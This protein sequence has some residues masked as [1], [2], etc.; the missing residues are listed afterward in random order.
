MADSQKLVVDAVAESVAAMD[1]DTST[2]TIA[3]SADTLNSAQLPDNK[4]TKD[5]EKRKQKKKEKKRAKKLGAAVAS[6]QVGSKKLLDLPIEILEQI[7]EYVLQNEEILL[8]VQ[9]FDPV[10]HEEF[11]TAKHIVS[12]ELRP[13]WVPTLRLVSTIF[14]KLMTPLIA[15][16][17]PLLVERFQNPA[18]ERPYTPSTTLPLR[19]L[20]PDYL[21]ARTNLICVTEEQATEH[22]LETGPIDVSGFPKLDSIRFGPYD[23]AHSLSTAQLRIRELGDFEE[24]RN[25]VL[26]FVPQRDD[27]AFP[28]FAFMVASRGAT[29]A[30][31]YVIRNWILPSFEYEER[32][33]VLMSLLAE[34]FWAMRRDKIVGLNADVPMGVEFLDFVRGE[35]VAISIYFLRTQLTSRIDWLFL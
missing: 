21:I 15:R 1:I 16:Y 6:A 7:F 3:A 9:Y 14:T 26:K 4:K 24:M 20:V 22:L 8:R 23:I 28:S 13:G 12:S 2:T 11:Q 32:Y 10:D 29:H 33:N 34:E 31:E 35:K 30:M 25:L 27:P 18:R 17:T 19:R 5:N